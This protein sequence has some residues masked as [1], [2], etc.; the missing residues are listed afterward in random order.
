MTMKT[1]AILL[2]ST[3]L[4]CAATAQ[5]SQTAP[6]GSSATSSTASDTSGKFVN[7][8][9][10]TQYR[11]SKFVGLGVYGSDN[12][13]IGDI[14]EVLIDAQGN[15]KTLVIGV[16][17][18]LGLGEKNVGVPFS[19]VEWVNTPIA[20]ANAGAAPRGNQPGSTVTSGGTS[21]LATNPSTNPSSGGTANT[22][23]STTGATGST[24]TAPVT[25]AP[26]AGAGAPMAGAT[27]D[28]T[29]AAGGSTTATGGTATGAA[30][31]PQAAPLLLAAR[32]ERRLGR[33]PPRAAAP[34]RLLP[35][36]ATRTTG[37]SA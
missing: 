36:T 21:G 10:M 34:P 26:T 13:R 17:G 7:E 27:G 3:A 16:G 9:A 32:Q 29:T 11:A 25:S 37:C 5:T 2:F 30:R 33:T 22:T 28:T 31:L 18:F 4:T 24:A 1:A 19:A 35:I 23:M 14:N 6:S 20:A 8:Q 15:A 12:T